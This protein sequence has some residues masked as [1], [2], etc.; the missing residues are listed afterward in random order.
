MTCWTK[1]V[2][3][4]GIF[5]VLI[6]F[7]ECSNFKYLTDI[8]QK[9]NKTTL[10]RRMLQ[11][12][13]RSK[14]IVAWPHVS[15]LVLWYSLGKQYCLLCFSVVQLDALLCHIALL[16]SCRIT[17]HSVVPNSAVSTLFVWRIYM[18]V[19]NWCDS[20]QHAPSAYLELKQISFHPFCTTFALNQ[21][22][23]LEYK[24]NSWLL[25]SIS[26]CYCQ[27]LESIR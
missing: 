1:Q 22:Y 11:A 16:M 17:L 8:Q 4:F 3:S 24:F 18:T 5:Y 7:T 19:L 14:F 27:L 2:V 26:F 23:C 10:Q 20:S 25:F 15:F 13:S 21:I 12:V 6:K 9:S